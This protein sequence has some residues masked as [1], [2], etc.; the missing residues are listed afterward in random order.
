MLGWRR[1]R[2]SRNTLTRCAPAPCPLFTRFWPALHP[3]FRWGNPDSCGCTSPQFV[4]KCSRW[5][6][7]CDL[8]LHGCPRRGI[9]SRRKT[10]TCDVFQRPYLGATVGQERS[11]TS[12]RGCRLPASS[13]GIS[14]EIADATRAQAIVDPGG[15]P[16]RADGASRALRPPRS[17]ASGCSAKG[18][19]ATRSDS[20]RSQ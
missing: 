15:P 11:V 17:G 4:E 6:S 5:L 2:P 18:W 9:V 10:G 7:R 12:G 20:Q 19:S 8:V 14:G 1:R 16:A 3:L 13:G